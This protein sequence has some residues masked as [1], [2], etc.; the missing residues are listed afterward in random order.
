MVLVF[1][2]LDGSGKTTLIQRL[3]GVLEAKVEA[4]PLV[5]LRCVRRQVEEV[6]QDRRW[7]RKLWYAAQV[8]E[9]SEQIRK[10]REEKRALL[11]DR[12]WLTTLAYARA[13]GHS[14]QLDHFE[15][16]LAVP[17]ITCFLD[18]PLSVR[19]E[20]LSARQEV[21]QEHDIFSLSVEGDEALRRHYLALSEHPAAGFFLHLPL[22]GH[23]S[24]EEMANRILAEV[25]KIA[26]GDS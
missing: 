5:A 3:A 23:E 15:E 7:A 2:G 17:D 1:E 25:N 14:I 4:T 10:C 8:A 20:R 26:R 16:S 9:A 21:L 22:L 11:V 24:T 6:L 12:Y 19:R 13:E 18:L